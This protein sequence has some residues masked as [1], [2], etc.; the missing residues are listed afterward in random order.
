MLTLVPQTRENQIAFSILNFD[1]DYAV[2]ARRWFRRGR[3]WAY[4]RI[5]LHMAFYVCRL[6]V[7]SNLCTFP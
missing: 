1:F 5:H 3:K 6:C 2:G 4:A 7:F